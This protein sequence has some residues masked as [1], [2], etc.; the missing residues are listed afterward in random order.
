MSV[1]SHSTSHS[2]SLLSL[3]CHFNFRLWCV[4]VLAVIAMLLP[5]FND[6]VGL[7]GSIGF[8]PL[9]VFLPIQ[10]HIVQA[11]VKRFSPKWIALQCL[12]TV[13]LLISL[14]GAVGS[15]AQIVIDCKDYTPFHTTYSRWSSW[16]SVL[17]D[18]AF[19]GCLHD[20]LQDMRIHP[21]GCSAAWHVLNWTKLMVK[22]EHL[23]SNKLQIV[24][25]VRSCCFSGTFLPSQLCPSVCSKLQMRVPAMELCTSSL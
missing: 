4:C 15:L 13:C 11:Q 2:T 12:S 1:C 23:T 16:S 20:C 7:L 24:N 8:W 25:S 10:M 5:F 22:V 3:V 6:I 21:F 18:Q 9:T 17:N 19:A 14:G